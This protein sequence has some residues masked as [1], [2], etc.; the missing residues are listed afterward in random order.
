M[1]HSE[2]KRNI[3]TKGGSLLSPQTI[4]ADPEM[5]REKKKYSNEW[6][7]SRGKGGG[8][9]IWTASRAFLLIYSYLLL[10]KKQENL[11]TNQ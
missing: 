7:G 4:Q 3:S 8:M 11:Y 6:K 10:Q 2:T 5:K 9:S 1:F